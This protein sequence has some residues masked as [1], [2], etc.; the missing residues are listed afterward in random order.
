MSREHPI[1]NST[2]TA[3]SNPSDCVLGTPPTN[4]SKIAR[5]C[6]PI[7]GRRAFL[8]GAAAVA[9]AAIAAS[10]SLPA[11]AAGLDPIFAAIEAHK[12]ANVA[13]R[14]QISVHSEL[15]CSLPR[16]KRKSNVDAFGEK[17]V[18]TDD[19]RWIAS[20]RAVMRSFEAEADAACVLVSVRP[21]TMAGMLA[22]LQYANAA[23]TDGE[24]WPCDL[25]SDDGKVR[26]WH[27]FLIESLVEV[28][29]GMVSA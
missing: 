18:P 26:S 12:A 7:P 28:L 16:E 9:T 17:I 8:S 13:L 20:E 24:A 6:A 15:E 25:Q 14:S 1:S 5:D 22:L 3:M 11:V 4:S 29:P 23:D 10:A 27:Y 21:T 2:E 19:P